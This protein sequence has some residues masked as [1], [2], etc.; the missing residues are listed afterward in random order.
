MLLLFLLTVLIFFIGTGYFKTHSF[1]TPLNYYLIFWGF[2][3]CISMLDP[4]GLYSVSDE[5]YLLLILNIAFFSLGFFSD[6][7]KSDYGY[8]N[9]KLKD[10]KSLDLFIIGSNF[11][12]FFILVHYLNKFNYLLSLSGASDARL[13]KYTAGKLFGTYLEYVFFS[14]IIETLVYL[15]VVYCICRYVVENKINLLLVQSVV[16]VIVFGL[17]GL[18]R[19]IVFDALMFYIVAQLFIARKNNS[20]KSIINKYNIVI[21]AVFLSSAILGMTVITASRLGN[22]VLSFNELLDMAEF[23]MNQAIMYF[24]GPFRAFDFFLNAQIT[25]NIGFMFGRATLSGIEEILSNF[26]LPFGYRWTTANA[27]IGDF[28]VPEIIIGS[29]VS[30][31]AFYTGVMNFYLDGGYI[32]VVFFAFI[33]GLVYSRIFHNYKLNYNIFSFCLFVYFTNTTIASAFRLPYHAPSVWF[34]IIIFI[35]ASKNCITS[36]L[37]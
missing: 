3:L 7:K 33:Y 9:I 19:F 18:G 36:K 21:A 16:N 26:F 22:K 5:G 15:S 34:V 6:T 20:I 1:K 31:N 28:T 13:I 14:Y 35:Y 4:F 27:L 37:R 24:I 29:N 11:F 17:I 8:V 30:F 10:S 12:I 23:T 25:D 32:G 2:W